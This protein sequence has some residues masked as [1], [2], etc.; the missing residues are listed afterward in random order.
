[1]SLLSIQ[2]KMTYGLKNVASMPALI[3]HSLSLADHNSLV[4]QSPHI[5]LAPAIYHHI[6]ILAPEQPPQSMPCQHTPKW[7]IARRKTYSFPPSFSLLGIVFC[8]ATNK[9]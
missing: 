7:L 9:Y 4:G 1:M 8:P 3:G 6:S 5:F 2:A